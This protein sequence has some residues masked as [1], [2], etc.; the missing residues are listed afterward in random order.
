MPTAT[1]T[2]TGMCKYY[3]NNTS[4]KVRRPFKEMALP[5]FTRAVICNVFHLAFWIQNY[6]EEDLNAIHNKHKEKGTFQRNQVTSKR[7]SQGKTTRHPLLQAHHTTKAPYQPH[8]S[9][10][11]DVSFQH[12][13]SIWI[14]KILLRTVFQYSVFLIVSKCHSKK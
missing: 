5:Y 3:S 12:S 4:N 6:L 11:L 10:T 2:G 13:L 7:E 8:L 9:S 1:A 14:K